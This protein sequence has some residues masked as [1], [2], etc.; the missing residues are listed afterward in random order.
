M[1]CPKTAVSIKAEEEF[2]KNCGLVLIRIFSVFVLSNSSFPCLMAKGNS[3]SSSGNF[4]SRRFLKRFGEAQITLSTPHN[5]R[6]M[7]RSL[8][9]VSLQMNKSK[10]H[11]S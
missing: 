10:L 2:T 11:K 5:A 8:G 4:G 3:R 9:S 6:A 1:A 7:I